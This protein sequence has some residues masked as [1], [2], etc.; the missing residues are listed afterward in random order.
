MKDKLMSIFVAFVRATFSEDRIRK[1]ISD[2][3]SVLYDQKV[4]DSD[5]V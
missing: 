4:G 1:L 2:L 3:L 5:E